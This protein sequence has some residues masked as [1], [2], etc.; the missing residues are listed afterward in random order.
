MV[1]RRTFFKTGTVLGMG[2]FMPWEL[3][4]QN[5]LTKTP[6]VSTSL[7]K[8]LNDLPIPDVISPGSVVGGVPLY[9]VGMTQFRQ[10]LHSQLPPTMVWGYNG[11]YP[12]PTFEVHSGAPIAVKW[13]NSLPSKHFLPIDPTMHGAEAPN[14]DVRS[15]VHLHG[16]KVLPDSDGYPEAWFTNDFAKTGPAFTRKIYQYPNDQPAT[17][18]WYHDHTLGS[19]RLN[20]FAGLEGFYFIRDA[21]EAALNLPSGAYEI[22]LMIQDRMF[23]TDGSLFYPVVDLTG[24]TDPTV[25]PVWVPEFFGDTA[26]VN[27]KVWPYLDVEPRKYRFR[28]LNGSN[29]RLWHLTLNESTRQ[30]VSLGRRG[31]AFHQIGSDG[32]FLPAPVTLTDMLIAPAE[33]FD[34]I[35]DFS[36]MQGKYFV[37]NND[38]AAPYPEGGDVVPAEVMLFKVTKP[39]RGPDTSS[40]P[41]RLAPVPL[42][43]PS[44]AHKRR[45]LILTELDS[46]ADNPIIGLL[47]NVRWSDPVIEKPKVGDTEIW[48]IMNLTGDTHPIHVHLVQFQVL[49]RQALLADAAGNSLPQVDPAAPQLAPDANERPAW[50][51]TVKCP[52]GTVT[53]IIAKFDLPSGTPTTPGQKFRYVWHCHIL[54]HEDNEM[55]RP[56]DVVA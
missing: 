36:G 41:A 16:A 50:K 12:G 1:S 43:R 46:A 38:G 7:T 30:G 18:L 55:M 48:N 25:P 4:A 28:F 45:D 9:E 5:A 31:P 14:P 49:D 2:L 8:F 40:L 33:R 17:S 13:I 42:I 27:G 10:K 15:V 19:T 56:F 54:E 22:P 29:A 39:L 44:A 47:D 24:E 6:L 53:R 20:V 21:D 26:L 3:I 51:D 52:P 23:N 32:G 34:V 35:I 11:S 37:L